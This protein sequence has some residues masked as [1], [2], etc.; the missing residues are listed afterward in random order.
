[1]IYTRRRRLN[2]KQQGR[3]IELLAAGATARAAAGITGVNRNIAR[4][5]YHR[6]RQLIASKLPS[7]DLA[8]EVEADERYFGGVRKGKRGREAARKGPLFGLLKR[9]WESIDRHYSECLVKNVTAIIRDSRCHRIASSMPIASRRM[10]CGMPRSFTT[11]VST[12][13]RSS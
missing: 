3:L 11:D 8:D 9:G 13:V 4:T 12:T 7:Y 10:I 2:R 6:L 1:M 5:F